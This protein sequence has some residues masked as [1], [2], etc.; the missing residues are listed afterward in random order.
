MGKFTKVRVGPGGIRHKV[1]GGSIVIGGVGARRH[2]GPTLS[3]EYYEDEN[4]VLYDIP[5]PK[6]PPPSSEAGRVIVRVSEESF[7]DGRWAPEMDGDRAAVLDQNED[8]LSSEDLDNMLEAMAR[9]GQGAKDE[10]GNQVDEEGNQ[11]EGEHTQLHSR[12]MLA[13]GLSFGGIACF[14]ACAVVM[15]LMFKNGGQEI[16]LVGLG[17]FIFMVLLGSCAGLLVVPDVMSVVSKLSAVGAEREGFAQLWSV[18]HSLKLR[19]V[20]GKTN[21]AYFELL[22]GDGQEDN[23]NSEYEEDL[24]GS[25]RA[26]LRAEP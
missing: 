2:F 25:S 9:Q 19:Y 17:G 3:G 20:G 21:P 24:P 5:K 18:D 22:P 4:G 6:P 23:N 15:M 26:L 7:F 12:M 1:I 8:W 11:V 13:G 16:V 14:F 10:E